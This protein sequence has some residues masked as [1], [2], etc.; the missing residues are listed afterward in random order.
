MSHVS[1]LTTKIRALIDDLS[2]TMTDTFYYT[3][4]STF[5]LTEENSI[6]E[7]S[8]EVNGNTSGITGTLDTSTNTVAVTGHS[9][10]SGDA[11][12]IQYTY[13]PMYSDTEIEDYTDASLVYLSISG[14]GNFRLNQ[15]SDE[16]TPYPSEKE[17][18]L[19]ALITAIIIKPNFKSYRTATIRYDTPNKMSKE[20]KIA[21]AI[22]RFKAFPRGLFDIIGEE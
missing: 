5:T 3:N 2:A 15:T 6:A 8:T 12:V 19:I 17:E 18:N 13:Y 9:F 22:T 16:I 21:E 11:V 14:I 4:S 20:E 1:R 7:V 10:S